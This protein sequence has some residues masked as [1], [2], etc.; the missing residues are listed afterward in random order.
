MAVLVP[1]FSKK[2]DCGTSI[3]K[4]AILVPLFYQILKFHLFLFSFD[5]VGLFNIMWHFFNLK[6]H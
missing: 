6:N 4:S 2:L 1:L 3:S 5:D